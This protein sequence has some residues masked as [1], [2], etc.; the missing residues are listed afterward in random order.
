MSANK[1]HE[2]WVALSDLFLDTDVA[3]HLKQ[4]SNVCADSDYS[5]EEIRNM[6]Y[7]DVAPVCMPNLLTVAGEWTGFD[8]EQLIEKISKYKN[9]KSST[10]KSL[11]KPQWGLIARIYIGKDWEKVAKLILEKRRATIG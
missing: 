5:V 6:L 11:F 4:I 9:K 8:E 2:I 10:I 1:E 3:I 7:Q